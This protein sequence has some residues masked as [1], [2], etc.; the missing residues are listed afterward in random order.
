MTKTV[1]SL[2]RRTAAGLMIGA[3]AFATTG[4]SAQA[5][6]AMAGKK[7]I[8]VPIAMGISLTEGWARR[9]K[10]HAT[11][12]G[13]TLDIRDPAFNTGVMSELLA[14]AISEKPDV[15]VVHNPTVQLLARQIRQ[16]EAQ[17]IK[18]LQINLQSSQPSTAFVGANWERIGHEIAEDIVK[19]CGTGSGKSGKVA[20]IPGQL[21]AADSVMMNEA[22]MKVFA[23]HPEI[24]VVSNQASDWEPE[25]ARQI[26]TT[27]LQQ[28]PDLCA[29]FGHWDVHTMG[30][31]N[32]VKDAGKT[33]DVLVYATGGGDDV[34][35][36]AVE[37]GVLDRVWSYDADGQGQDAGEIV[38]RL[39]QG[40]TGDGSPLQVESKLK[41]IKA[42]AS[43][44]PSLCWK[45]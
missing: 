5:E 34:T 13:Y 35:C 24:E 9:M 2:M 29:I 4:A 11:A 39:L 32:A 8:F 36:K 27:V 33:D 10:E 22:A 30:A 40:A 37:D 42:G 12:N 23:E 43:Y 45:R 21:T 15:L 41:I 25:K 3:V 44:D 1:K 19:E 20:I 26:T 28:S 14:K 6:G 16:A 18:V 7:V 38:D 17:G 31:G